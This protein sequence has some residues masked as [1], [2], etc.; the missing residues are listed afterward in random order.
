MPTDGSP[1]ITR[2]TRETKERDLPFFS[3]SGKWIRI[4]QGWI[5][6]EQVN[7]ILPPGKAE[8]PMLHLSAALEA[9]DKAAGIDIEVLALRPDNY[10]R[11]LAGLDVEMA[12]DTQS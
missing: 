2:L 3:E 8:R 5:K 7:L 9:V 10:R 11:K 12:N 4:P 6:K 1:I